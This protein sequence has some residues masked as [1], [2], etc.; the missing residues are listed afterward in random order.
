MGGYKCKPICQ[1]SLSSSHRAQSCLATQ[2]PLGNLPFNCSKMD[3]YVVI[4]IGDKTF[5]TDTHSSGGKTPKWSNVFE[6]NRK[7]ED[8]ME[9]EIFDKD[10]VSDDT[11]GKGTFSISN[12]CNAPKK[13]FAG[14]IQ[15]YHKSKQAG[16]VYFEID[17]Y[18]DAPAG[19]PG[20]MG[21][22][23]PG[24]MGHGPPGRGYPQQQYPPHGMHGRPG[25]PPPPQ[26][27]R[28]R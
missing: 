4:K 1:G 27:G 14:P 25:M 2:R 13:N 18:P 15:I 10:K 11:I 20:G 9:F 28:G 24:G 12:L 22:G 5:K 23:P 6:F 19:G 3:P 26:R 21:Y 16:E 8:T 7:T 17:F